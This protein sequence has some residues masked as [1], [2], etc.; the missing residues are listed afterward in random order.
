MRTNESWAF[1]PSRVLV[2]NHSSPREIRSAAGVATTPHRP[3]IRLAM[4]ACP[5]NGDGVTPSDSYL[6]QVTIMP[7][8]SAVVA[9]VPSD[10]KGPSTALEPGLLMPTWVIGH[11]L[12]PVA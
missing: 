3:G 6:G 5:A 10:P 9:A 11:A 4:T 1:W 12:L 8:M 2:C 7:V